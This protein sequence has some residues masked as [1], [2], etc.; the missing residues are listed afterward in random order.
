MHLKKYL[1]VAEKDAN[2]ISVFD[3]LNG[4]IQDAIKT[5]KEDLEIKKHVMEELTE[6]EKNDVPEEVDNPL[7]DHQ[8]NNVDLNTEDQ[9]EVL[10]NDLSKEENDQVEKAQDLNIEDDNTQ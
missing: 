4:S 7:S 9:E 1:E 10:E 3:F 5:A 2:I 8:D 6:I